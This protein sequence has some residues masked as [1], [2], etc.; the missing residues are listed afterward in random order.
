MLPEA[1]ESL[2]NLAPKGWL[3]FHTIIFVSICT[4]TH[5]D[6]VTVSEKMYICEF[7]YLKRELLTT[8][9]MELYKRVCAVNK[10]Q[11][12]EIPVFSKCS[13]KSLLALRVLYN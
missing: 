4:V 10:E 2:L 12:S 6:T 8:A 9:N 3:T 13:Y 1:S 7:F 5:C 11:K